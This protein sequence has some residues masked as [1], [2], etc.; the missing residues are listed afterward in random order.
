MSS[1]FQ[2]PVNAYGIL[3]THDNE[4]D[5][6]IDAFLEIGSNVTKATVGTVCTSPVTGEESKRYIDPAFTNPALLVKRTIASK[7]ILR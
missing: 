1:F 2:Q 4:T 3:P 5:I 6:G 7:T